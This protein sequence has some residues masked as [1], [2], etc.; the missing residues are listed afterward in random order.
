MGLRPAAEQ[1]ELEIWGQQPGEATVEQGR[2]AAIALEELVVFGFD[3]KA[4]VFAE[5]EGKV[6]QIVKLW[7]LVGEVPVGAD[8]AQGGNAV[9]DAFAGEEA[10]LQVVSAGEA[11]GQGGAVEGEAGDVAEVEGVVAAFGEYIAA[12]TE[13]QVVDTEAGDRGIG[14]AEFIR[15]E[16]GNGLKKT[17]LGKAIQ[18]GCQVYFSAVV[19]SEPSK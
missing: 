5:V 13:L 15:P 7:Q 2:V 18:G 19:E 6:D 4:H 12:E 9:A 8:V 11:G 10:K 17:A 16:I 1:V 3:E 14:N